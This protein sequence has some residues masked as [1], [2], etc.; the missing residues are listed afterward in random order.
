MCRSVSPPTDGSAGDAGTSVDARNCRR[1]SRSCHH[2]RTYF[3]LECRCNCSG[4]AAC[5]CS[6]YGSFCDRGGQN[7]SFATSPGASG[8]TAASDPVVG[9][10]GRSETDASQSSVPNRSTPMTS[11]GPYSGTGTTGATGAASSA[12]GRGV[13]TAPNGRPIGSIGSGPGS[14]EEPL[15][16][17][18]R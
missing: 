1:V 11:S 18:K 17:V 12:P 13:G 7:S 6:G 14:P 8:G 10:Y 15:D 4:G 3:D 2:D 5:I 16:S 9:T